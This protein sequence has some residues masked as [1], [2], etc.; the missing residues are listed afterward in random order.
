MNSNWFKKY[1][2]VHVPVHPMGYLVTLL[3]ILFMVPVTLSVIR[4]GHSVSDDLYTLFV[5]GTCTSY[6]WNRLAEISSREK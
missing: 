1:K 3:A 6:W 4:N 5:F 2:W